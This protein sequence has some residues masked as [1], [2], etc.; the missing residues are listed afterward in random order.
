[1]GVVSVSCAQVG[2]SFHLFFPPVLQQKRPERAVA[3]QAG[4]PFAFQGSEKQARQ[5]FCR[6][7]AAP[8][9]PAV[10]MSGVPRGSVTPLILQPQSC[11]A[12]TVPA[13]VLRASRGRGQ[14]GLAG[15]LGDPWKCF[16][17]PLVK[18][19]AL[20]ALP[21]A[22][23]GQSGGPMGTPLCPPVNPLTTNLPN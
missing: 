2:S 9:P 11:L 16:G 22:A 17:F 6:T 14:P 12:E 5:Q 13:T 20:A 18:G 19:R 1:M 7:R 15:G 10:P 21:G 3:E 23:P 4:I 8:L